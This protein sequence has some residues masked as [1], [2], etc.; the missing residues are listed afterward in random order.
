M[1]RCGQNLHA[2]FQHKPR[3]TFHISLRHNLK[4]E[5]QNKKKKKKKSMITVRVGKTV[6]WKKALCYFSRERIGAGAEKGELPTMTEEFS[7]QLRPGEVKYHWL[8]MTYHQSIMIDYSP[9]AMAFLKTCIM[10]AEMY[11]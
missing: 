9:N 7:F 1:V 10:C 8:K 11:G 3:T 2:A 6:A 4:P 5:T